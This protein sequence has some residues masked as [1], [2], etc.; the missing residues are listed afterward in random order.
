M[1]LILFVLHDPEKLQDVLTAWE[2]VGVS[3]AT[4]FNSTGM[5]RILKTQALREDMPLM[6]SI[7]DFFPHPERES[8]TIFTVIKDEELIETVARATEGVIGDLDGPD[9]GFL[10]A[11]PTTAAY[12][13]NKNRT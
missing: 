2:E 9:T 8:C 4:V 1:N 3:G 6:P 12:G 13:I 5:G 11:I 7:D 10:V